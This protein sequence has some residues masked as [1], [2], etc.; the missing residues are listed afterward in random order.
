VH[1]VMRTVNDLYFVLHV[2]EFLI[3]PLSLLKGV[4]GKG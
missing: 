3:S 4:A 2:S 1:L